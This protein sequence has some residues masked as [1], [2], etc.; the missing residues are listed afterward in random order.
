MK[1]LILL[2]ALI[3]I[4][5][6]P[7]HAQRTLYASP[8]VPTDDPGGSG[9]IFLPWDVI[10]YKGGLYTP[11]PVLTFPVNTAVDALHK[12][13]RSGYW[14]FS[15]EAMTE[16][17]PGGGVYYK[18]EDV[19]LYDGSNYFLFYDGSALGVPPGVNVDAAFL[20]SDD[21]GDLVISFDVPTSIGA[22]TYEPA[23]LVRYHG[24]G[25]YSLFYDASGAGSGVTPATNVTGADATPSIDILSFDIPTDAAPSLGPPTY[26]PGDIA[27]WNGGAYSI[28]DNLAGWPLSNEVDAFSC[29]ANP[30]RVYDRSVYQ[31]PILIAKSL[32]IPGN[33][34]LSW[35]PSCSSGAED[36]GIYEGTLGTWYSHQR[37]YCN[38]IDGL[39]YSED[40]PPTPGGDRY[41]L[42]VPHN[43]ADEGAYGLDHLP[44]RVPLRIERPQPA[45]LANRC[46]VPQA[47]TACP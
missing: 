42:V 10:E 19:I 26:I 3:A 32:A 2:M 25:V 8:D 33:V 6:P 14:L 16:L 5:G 27:S 12:M 37:L 13:D 39:T 28:Y 30:G 20:I 4:L 43:H 31:L 23:D 18:P 41:Y 7:I 1:R 24:G 38:D 36:Y 22:A 11:F 46:Y 29:Q 45:A 35:A 47:V 44:T 21:Y 15:V 34:V 40:F 17:P 9:T